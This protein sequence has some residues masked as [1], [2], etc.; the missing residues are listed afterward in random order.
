MKHIIGIKFIP[1]FVHFPMFLMRPVR[2]HMMTDGYP[3]P[4]ITLSLV[5]MR[6]LALKGPSCPFKS[7]GL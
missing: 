4:H 5:F 1:F 2:A 3:Y 6:T 7:L